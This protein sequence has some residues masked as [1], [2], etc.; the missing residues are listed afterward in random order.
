MEGNHLDSPE[1][2]KGKN[3]RK[4]SFLLSIFSNQRLLNSLNAMEITD[5][6]LKKR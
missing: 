6:F 2:S 3:G 4:M 5:G 1:H